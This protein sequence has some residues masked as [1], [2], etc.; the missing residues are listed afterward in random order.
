MA[1]GPLYVPAS[2]SRADLCGGVPGRSLSVSREP[3]DGTSPAKRA[4]ARGALAWH[5]RVRGAAGDPDGSGTAVHRVA[6]IDGVRGGVEAPRYPTHEEPSA[7]SAD[8]RQDRAVLEDLV[9]GVAL[10]H[11]VRRLR[12]LPA[13]RGVVPPALQLPASSPGARGLDARGPVLPRRE[14][15]AREHRGASGRER[16]APGATATAAQAV[17]PRRSARRSG[18]CH[19]RERRGVVGAGGR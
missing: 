12:G 19:Q 7:S 11:G 18:A 13:P 3:C 4:G 10:A 15:S 8:L 5:R 1:V 2:S 14:S 16:A 17:L 6:R 9:G